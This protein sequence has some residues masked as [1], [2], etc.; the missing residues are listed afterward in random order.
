MY[1]PV[2][3]VGEIGSIGRFE[4]GHIVLL[5]S[6]VPQNV[7][8]VYKRQGEKLTVT[9]KLK[10]DSGNARLYW[11]D[12]DIEKTIA[13]TNNTDT[14]S[15]KMDAGDNY[16][17]IEGN[18]F[19]GSLHITVKRENSDIISLNKGDIFDFISESLKTNKM[20]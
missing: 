18:D 9:Y 16:I 11:L 4:A 13:D 3:P 17:A 5:A 10:V 6:K 7:S 15:I 14:Y 12:E 1:R 2:L 8:D 19:R 20:R